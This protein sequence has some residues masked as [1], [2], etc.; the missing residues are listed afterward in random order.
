MSAQAAAAQAAA[1]ASL[2]ASAAAA[3]AAPNAFTT[4]PGVAPAPVGGTAA[5]VPATPTDSV[6]SLYGGMRTPTGAPVHQQPP[7]AGRMSSSDAYDVAVRAGQAASDAVW[8]AAGHP[9]AEGPY[10]QTYQ[11]QASQ[12]QT[13]R[14]LQQAA[15]PTTPS[16][17]RMVWC[18]NRNIQ[19]APAQEHPAAPTA[20]T[21]QAAARSRFSRTATPT[22]RKRSCYRPV[23][24]AQHHISTRPSRRRPLPKPRRVGIAAAA[25]AQQPSLQKPPRKQQRQPA[26]RRD[27]GDIAPAGCRSNRRPGDTNGWTTCRGACGNSHASCGCCGCG[28]RA[29]QPLHAGLSA[30]GRGGRPLRG[31][32]GSA[33]RC[34]RA[35]YHVQRAQ[36][37]APAQPGLAPDL[38]P[39]LLRARGRVHSQC[40]RDGSFAL[41]FE[42][43]TRCC[44][45]GVARKMCGRIELTAPP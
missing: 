11:S 21:C 34:A 10:W 37:Y 12:H 3:P 18:G 15:T 39:A 31:A 38:C 30:P 43:Q 22:C 44:L 32:T 14:G 17:R 33:C 29:T 8:A 28:R 24:P 7:A 6:S 19:R 23:C 2:A 45:H 35:H 27:R 16:S 26:R 5:P 40:S 25:H 42:R 4:T 36:Q 9:E 13:Q 20:H 41:A 1:T